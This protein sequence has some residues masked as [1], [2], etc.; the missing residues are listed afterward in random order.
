MAKKENNKPISY[1]IKIINLDK[2]QKQL[3]IVTKLADKLD[4]EMAKL[5][6]IEMDVEVE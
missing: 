4:S 2:F 6:K 1:S 5:R 3:K